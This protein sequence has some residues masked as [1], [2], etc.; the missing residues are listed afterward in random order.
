MAQTNQPAYPPLASGDHPWS[1]S[2]GAAAVS[3]NYPVDS[4]KQDTVY[5]DP[6]R[7]VS[8]SGDNQTVASSAPPTVQSTM[9]LPNASH[10]HVPYSSSL[11]HGYNPAEYGNYYYNYPQ[12]TNNYSAQQGGANQHSGA[13]Y[14]PLTSFQNS[15]SYV[16]P[17]SNTYYNAGAD[18]TAPGY[19]T[20]NYYYQ[21]NAWGGGSSGDVHSQTYQTYNPSDANAAQNSSSLPT[22]SFHYPQQYTQW[23]H[24]YDQSAPNSVGSAVAG[25]SVSETKACS[26]GSGYAHP[27]SQPPPPGTTQWKNDTVASTAPPLQVYYSYLVSYF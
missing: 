18:Q 13:A 9:S 24:Y 17:T 5:Y 14:Q 16:G 26:A 15:G 7:D 11:Q 12:A 8:V 1:S 22:N 21:N 25:S 27:S 23:S 2:T 19:A 4:Q 10:S 20:N 3:W 6:Q